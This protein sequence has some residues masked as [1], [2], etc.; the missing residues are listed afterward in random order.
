MG[1]I[2]IYSP[3]FFIYDSLAEFKSTGGPLNEKLRSIY[4]CNAIQNCI[5]FKLGPFIAGWGGKTWDLI[6]FYFIGSEQLWV[7][8]FSVFSSYGSD[9]MVTS[10]NGKYSLTVITIIDPLLWLQLPLSVDKNEWFNTVPENKR[11]RSTWKK[12]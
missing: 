1:I 2:H 7:F 8:L 3:Y 10:F 9:S 4:I 11:Q 6:L 12:K 5:L